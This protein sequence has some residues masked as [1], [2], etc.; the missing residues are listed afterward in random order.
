MV[1]TGFCTG[2]YRYVKLF[3]TVFCTRTAGYRYSTD[4][5]ELEQSNRLLLPALPRTAVPGIYC[6]RLQGEIFELLS[7]LNLYV[8]LTVRVL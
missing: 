4:A 1:Y 8:P 7:T 6:L 5:Y 3:S 2:T